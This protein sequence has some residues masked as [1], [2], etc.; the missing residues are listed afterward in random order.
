MAESRFVRREGGQSTPLS[1]T[2]DG[3]PATARAGD[4]VAAALLAHDGMAT[5]RTGISHRGINGAL[6]MPFCM[7]GV[8]F[9]CVVTIDGLPN[10]QACMI[11]LTQ[12]MDVRRQSGFRK[13]EGQT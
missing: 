3:Q 9:D 2:I 13:L 10:Q 12:G 6:R 5:R 1:F 4:T 7:M 8:C 11:D